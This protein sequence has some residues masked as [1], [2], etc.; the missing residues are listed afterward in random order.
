VYFGQAKMPR[1]WGIF[2]WVFLDCGASFK[3]SCAVFGCLLMAWD[4][5]F[6]HV[7]SESECC[8]EDIE[9][10]V[11]PKS[12]IFEFFAHNVFGFDL[13]SQIFSGRVYG[14][15]TRRLQPAEHQNVS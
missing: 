9:L 15:A 4:V 3:D 8:R 6:R 14:V 13:C 2:R 10:V 5:L 7:S 1:K 11:C 12:A